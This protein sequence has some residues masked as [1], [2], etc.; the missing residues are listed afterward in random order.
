MVAIAEKS[1]AQR[2][3]EEGIQKEREGLGPFVAAADAT[4]MP[5]IFTDARIAANPII[6]ANKSFLKLTG[7]K[8]EE[9]LGQTVGFVLSGFAAM[10]AIQRLEQAMT[11]AADDDLEL[12]CR[13]KDGSNFLASI[14]L[15]PIRDE[16]GAVVQ[17]FLSFI[18]LT[19]HVDRLLKE[20]DELNTRYQH[21][22]GFIAT[23][24][25]PEHCFSSIN[26]AYETLVGR[27]GLRGKTVREALP[28]PA[29]QN[30][31][32]RLDEVRASGQRFIAH[33]LSVTLT[34]PSGSIERHYLNFIL[35][36]IRGDDG[37]VSGIFCQGQDVTDQKAAVDQVLLLQDELIHLSRVSAIGTMATTLAH[38]LT[39]PLTAIANYSAASRQ[40][41]D[42][43]TPRAEALQQCL[44]GISEGAARA[45]EVIR[46]LR[47]MTKRGKP[48]RSFFDL[49]EAIEECILLVRAGR[50]DLVQIDDESSQGLIVEADRVQ[51]QQVL[52]NLVRNS[53]EAMEHSDRRVVTVRAVAQDD[54]VVVAVADTGPGV[55]LEVARTIFDWS[56]SSK[57]DGMGIGLSI[58]KTIIEAH[59]GRIWLED[60]S[61][62]G[63]C[64]AFSL[65]RGEP[66]A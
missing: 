43:E 20:R 55:P 28:E 32:A 40:L 19:G 33:D 29:W 39:Q 35:Q 58:S 31:I 25:G 45:G 47:D 51:I 44:T 9:V 14:F 6:F 15:S 17:H 21:A 59:E 3:A 24:T 8:R 50:V 2:R 64:L 7:Y 10:E 57:A 30:F 26:T 1:G 56:T 49:H 48:Q 12:E 18:E 53:C 60:S 22:P 16:G 52:L 62:T 27:T 13:R 54:R 66:V 46:H 11:D 37:E 61:A 38:E 42:P 65:P 63:S 5:M 23:L 4:R 34:R 41:V 36:P